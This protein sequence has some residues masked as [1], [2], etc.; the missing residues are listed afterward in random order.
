MSRTAKRATWDASAKA[1]QMCI[2]FVP[3]ERSPPG[4]AGHV[5]RG[6]MGI[7]YSDNATSKRVHRA[8][9][10]ISNLEQSLKDKSAARAL[11]LN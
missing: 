6:K 8:W 2:N 10:N 9:E 5:W 1:I 4:I 3:L 7:G 11:R